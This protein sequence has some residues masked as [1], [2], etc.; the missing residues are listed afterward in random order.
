M[1]FG[2]NIFHNTDDI[3]TLQNTAIYRTEEN[4]KTNETVTIHTMNMKTQ[5]TGLHG[6]IC[7]N[8]SSNS[9]NTRQ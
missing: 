4:L 6:L 8:N 3:K 5:T 2:D 9:R 7:E 1:S